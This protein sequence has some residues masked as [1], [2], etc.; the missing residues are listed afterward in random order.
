M[1]NF[2]MARNQISTA[3]ELLAE[4]LKKHK[5]QY[6]EDNYMQAFSRL[7]MAILGDM[8]SQSAVIE[9]WYYSS[10]VELSYFNDAE[11]C[12]YQL[13]SKVSSN[14]VIVKLSYEQAERVFKDVC[15]MF[16]SLK[17]FS[18]YM[19]ADYQQCTFFMNV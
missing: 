2:E 19:K 1:S 7:T 15:Y 8:L 17:D 10:S 11:H 3:S 12:A 16:Q 18:A 13:K 14:D 9:S 4:E 6:T 5:R